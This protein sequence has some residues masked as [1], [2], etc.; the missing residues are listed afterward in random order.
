MSKMFVDILVEVECLIFHRGTRRTEARRNVIPNPKKEKNKKMKDIQIEVCENPYEVKIHKNTLT[1]SARRAEIAKL[2][3]KNTSKDEI[4][5]ILA[6]DYGICDI[7]VALNEIRQGYVYIYLNCEASTEEI[8]RLSLARLEQIYDSLEKDASELTKKDN[9]N[10]KLKTI[11]LSAKVAGVY[12][13]QTNVNV[14]GA[15]NFTVNLG[16]PIETKTDEGSYK[17]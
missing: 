9:L 12:Q 7:S 13:P 15:E 4:I 5:R 17:D 1:T 14:E 6:D 16:S 8:K 11:D 2:I 10:L 3:M